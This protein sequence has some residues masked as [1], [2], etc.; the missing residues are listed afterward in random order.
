MTQTTGEPFGEQAHLA[1]TVKHYD[2][3]ERDAGPVRAGHGDAAH[4]C[5]AIAADILREHTVRGKV[6][7]QG[8]ALAAACKRCGDAIWNMR[9][10]LS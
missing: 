5:D 9:E 1:F 10:K 4:M 6:T 7:K 2:L 3:S 8:R